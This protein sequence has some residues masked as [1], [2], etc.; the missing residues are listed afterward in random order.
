MGPDSRRRR[1]AGTPIAL[2][3]RA[4][5]PHRKRA[6]HAA[7]PKPLCWSRSPL[8][9]ERSLGPLLYAP[10]RTASGAA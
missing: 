6:P 9:R 2:S 5:P 4:G 3:T 8:I 10:Q 1:T 7:G